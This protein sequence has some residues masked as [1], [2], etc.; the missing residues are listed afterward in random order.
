MESPSRPCDDV[1]IELQMALT[2]APSSNNPLTAAIIP[3]FLFNS[4]MCMNGQTCRNWPLLYLTLYKLTQLLFN[5]GNDTWDEST[6]GILRYMSVFIVKGPSCTSPTAGLGWS[7]TFA[8]LTSE[9]DQATQMCSKQMAL[10][11]FPGFHRVP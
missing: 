11:H 9:F 5:T 1:N 4:T 6:K 8:P 10:Q 7:G 2:S 3:G